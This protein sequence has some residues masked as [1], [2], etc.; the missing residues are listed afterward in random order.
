MV[1]A[2]QKCLQAARLSQLEQMYVQKTVYRRSRRGAVLKF[3]REHYLRDDLE[4]PTVATDRDTVVFDA[5]CLV[6][7]RDLLLHPSTSAQCSFLLLQSVLEDARSRNHRGYRQ[8]REHVLQNVSLKKQGLVATLANEHLR[9]TRLRRMPHETA[10]DRRI[11][12]LAVTY[13]WLQQRWT[14]GT[15]LRV[16]CHKADTKQRLLQLGVAHVDTVH[17][18]TQRVLP[19]L[20][21][22]LAADEL[23]QD[24]TGDFAFEE[25]W[26][27]EQVE[28]AKNEGRVVTGKINVRRGGGLSNKKAIVYAKGLDRP[29]EIRGSLHAP[30]LDPHLGNPRI[31]RHEQHSACL[32]RLREVG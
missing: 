19:S 16:V 8:L 1:V 14:C 25:F 32:L 28:V 29:V 20:V 2:V 3:S 7:Q 4:A 12:T 17:E 15:T 31:Y 22:S 23:E 10:R 5:D 30:R 6:M 26:S 24:E 27:A 9:E 21:D 13:E 11:R 18:W